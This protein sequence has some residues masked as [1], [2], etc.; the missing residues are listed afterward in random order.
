MMKDFFYELRLLFYFNQPGSDK[1]FL[2]SDSSSIYIVIRTVG[3][4]FSTFF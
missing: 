3:I 1:M 2:I 4:L